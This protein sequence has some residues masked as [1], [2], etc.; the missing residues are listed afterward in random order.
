MTSYS[1]ISAP[2]T[3]IADVERSKKGTIYPKGTIYVQISACKKG[4]EHI[5]NILSEDGTIESKY[6][7]VRMKIPCIP[8]YLCVAL[9]N[10]TLE[11]MHKYVGKNIN[12]SLDLFRYLVVRYHSEVRE[13]L[14]V[15]AA[16]KPIQDEI[17]LIKEQIAREKE[18]K[19][20]FL[21]KMM[22]CV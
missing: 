15:L 3:E 9:E 13:Q 16:L 19:K 14:E 8:E 7:V 11:W 1:L 12:I 10:V 22:T 17:E 18:T 4:T 6:A 20:W 21:G 5:W 2:L